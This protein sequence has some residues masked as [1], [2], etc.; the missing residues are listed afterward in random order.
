MIQIGYAD[1]QYNE[2]NPAFPPPPIALPPSTVPDSTATLGQDEMAAI[3]DSGFDDL[4]QPTH[5]GYAPAP[6]P[7]HNG[8]SPH[9]R[10]QFAHTNGQYEIGQYAPLDHPHLPR[11]P[12]SADSI[13][14]SIDS[15][16][17]GSG[18]AKKRS[19]GAGQD[20]YGPLGPLADDDTGWGAQNGGGWRGKMI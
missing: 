19:G 16:Q 14:S 7:F 9:S 20:R 10:A 8:R 3:L 1:L 15:R 5:R 11:D 2:H 4:P 12:Q 6:N 17:G 13:S 18:H